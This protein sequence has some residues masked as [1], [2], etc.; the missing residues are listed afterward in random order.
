MLIGTTLEVTV[1][2]FETPTGILADLLSRRL[3][4]IIGLF[5]FGIG[6]LIEGSF[7][8]FGPLLLGTVIWGLG[9]TFISGAGEAWIADELI[10]T[11]GP[12]LQEVF[13]RGTQW[14]K[15]GELIAVPVSIA[16]ATIA[17][18]LPIII[19]GLSHLALALFL[20]F[21]MPEDGFQPAQRGA[22]QPLRQLRAG[23][24][25]VRARTILLFVMGI[26]L[27]YGMYSE[28]FDRLWTKHLL[29]H[30]TLPSLGNLPIIVWWGILSG[31]SS[32]LAIF[33]AEYSRRNQQ[34]SSGSRIIWPLLSITIAISFGIFF[35]ANI[36][37]LGLALLAYICITALRTLFVPLFLAWI[38]DFIQSEVRATLNSLIWQVDSVGQIAGGPLIGY[39][40][41]RFSTRW[42]MSCS[43]FLLMP[44][45]WI[46]ARIS[47]KALVSP[48]ALIKSVE[49][50]SET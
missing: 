14:K 39:V 24:S 25:A 38:N 47:R 37:W 35:Y 2:L 32:L 1:L 8:A 45:A 9:I 41:L 27:F 21:V 20:V 29:D 13:L 5:L 44:A 18:P 4:F 26:A 12:P 43:A 15:I 3:S 16:L 40:G 46:F 36:R 10:V 30:F 50:K 48:T 7:P 33:L 49:S 11:K 42:A 17:V 31:V 22:R 6:F 34:T 19:A 28:G 23:I